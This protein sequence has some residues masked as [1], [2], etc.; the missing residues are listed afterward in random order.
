MCRED[1]LISVNIARTL[2]NSN[3]SVFSTLGCPEALEGRVSADE[4]SG[5]GKART[6][7]PVRAVQETCTDTPGNNNEVGEQGEKSDF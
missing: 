4:S 2:V 3:P 1:E 7:K 5:W 6:A